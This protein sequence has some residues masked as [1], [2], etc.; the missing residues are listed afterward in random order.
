MSSSKYLDETFFADYPKPPAL[1]LH[2]SFTLPMLEDKNMLLRFGCGEPKEILRV[3]EQHCIIVSAGGAALYRPTSDRPAFWEIDCPATCGALSPNGRL[4]AI[5]G[6]LNSIYVWDLANGKL[7]H[8]VE[9][10]HQHKVEELVFSPDGRTLVSLGLDRAFR[11]WSVAGMQLI[12]D[13]RSG[14][15]PVGAA[16]WSADGKQ[17]AVPAFGKKLFEYDLTLRDAANGEIIARQLAHNSYI[18]KIS[19]N[20][21]QTLLASAS[22]DGTVKIWQPDNLELKA[23]LKIED[24]KTAL[25]S[26]AWS[27][28]GR[29]LATGSYNNNLMVWEVESKR[30]VLKQEAH[31]WTVSSLEWFNNNRQIVTV[32]PDTGT[33]VWSVEGKLLQE[34]VDHSPGVYSLAWHPDSKTLAVG[35]AEKKVKLWS[36]TNRKWERNLSENSSRINCVAWN[37]SGKYFASGAYNGKIIVWTTADW[38]VLFEHNEHT[39]ELTGLTF[40]PSKRQLAS[41][42]EDRTII[43]YSIPDGTILRQIE[44]P[45]RP[46]GITYSPDGK[47]LAV[48][49]YQQG[50]QLIATGSW[51]IVKTAFENTPNDVKAL[52]F[53][54]TGQELAFNLGDKSSDIWAVES[55]QKNAALDGHTKK[56]VSLNWNIDNKLIASGSLDNNIGLWAKDRQ[57]QWQPR[58]LHGHISEVR[59]VQFS[60]NGRMLA[61]GDTEGVVR[62][63]Q[64]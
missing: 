24:E 51:E 33:R 45:S 31:T 6:V 37:S 36:L 20:P 59:C 63:W 50:I 2:G 34:R 30:L 13:K 48:S 47:Y 57:G 64:V 39:R 28:D 17:L 62:I 54:P 15:G 12:V 58:W 60:P 46:T 41:C 9:K 5:A 8:Q 16:A 53:S 38:Q 21:A 14:D 43:I 29:Y 11:L 35:A 1:D 22:S 3:D 23:T 52:A 55:W 32:S 26:M 10:A 44:I 40:H 18:T 25:K 7:V 61:T 19:Y 49:V 56:I 42:S 4:L 27:S